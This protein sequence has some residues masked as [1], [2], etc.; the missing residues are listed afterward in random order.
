MKVFLTLW[1][2]KLGW[3]CKSKSRSCSVSRTQ[4]AHTDDGG[5]TV[6][7]SS[8]D[9]AQI[10]LQCWD[11]IDQDFVEDFLCLPLFVSTFISLVSTTLPWRHFLLTP[12]VFFCNMWITC[13]G[14]VQISGG[15]NSQDMT[16][17]EV[18]LWFISGPALY[19]SSHQRTDTHADTFMLF[20]CSA[21]DHRG[22]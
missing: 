14:C 4:N 6:S 15:L 12:F 2:V 3:Y 22:H 16:D 9:C 10:C 11:M 18:C 19:T 7:W 5:K 1:T 20:I 21:V 17:I 13:A 8:S